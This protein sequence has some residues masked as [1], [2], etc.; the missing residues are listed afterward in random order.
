MDRVQQKY[1]DSKINVFKPRGINTEEEFVKKY[2]DELWEKDDT[3]YDY[4]VKVE[5]SQRAYKTLNANVVLTGRRKSQGG[6]R[7]SLPILEKDEVNNIL[8]IN[9]LWNWDFN[10]V[11]S[12]IDENNVPFNELLNLGYKSVG[13]WH[14]TVPVADGEDE[15]AGRWKD[16]V[17]TECGIHI[18]KEF[19]HY[20]VA[21]DNAQVTKVTEVKVD[22]NGDDSA[23]GNANG[24]GSILVTETKVSVV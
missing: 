16:K 23:N 24:N 3:Y 2:G 17:K 12:Y 4:L 11:K 8:K 14:S 18:A 7:S 6:A 20:N 9:P 1:P 22:A 5:P 21:G 10:Q 19:T 15:R 13:D